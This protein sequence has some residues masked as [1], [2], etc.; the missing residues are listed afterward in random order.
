MQ[1]A[2]VALVG[3]MTRHSVLDSFLE[4]LTSPAYAVL[5]F[6]LTLVGPGAVL[7]VLFLA[8]SARLPLWKWRAITAIE[9]MLVFTYFVAALPAVQ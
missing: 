2:G 8:R 5:C 9:A 6:I 3:A 7:P 1:L 4:T